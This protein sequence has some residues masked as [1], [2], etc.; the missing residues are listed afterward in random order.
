MKCGNLNLKLKMFGCTENGQCYGTPSFKSLN[1][2]AVIGDDTSLHKE[3]KLAQ[4]LAHTPK[5]TDIS[6]QLQT[7]ASVM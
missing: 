3:V 4:H 2:L 6:T 1:G 7:K 5:N